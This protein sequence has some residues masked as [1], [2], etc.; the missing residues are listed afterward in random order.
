MLFVCFCFCFCVC[1]FGYNSSI[2]G[3]QRRVKR[4]ARVVQPK[5]L[6]LVQNWETQQEKLILENYKKNVD[7]I[8]CFV[9][10]PNSKKN[11]LLNAR[12]KEEQADNDDP[13]AASFVSRNLLVEVP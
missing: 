5:G 1:C 10:N 12:W 7:P 2:I 11:I 8:R 6:K 9:E 3:H 13:E 4:C